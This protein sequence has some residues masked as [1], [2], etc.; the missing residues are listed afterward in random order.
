MKITSSR[1]DYRLRVDNVRVR[2]AESKADS[3]YDVESSS[4]IRVANSWVK[5]KPTA[6][7]LVFNKENLIEFLLD[8][9]LSRTEQ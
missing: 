4:N 3:A 1:N 5:I 8:S 6:P 9:V 7:L 2:W